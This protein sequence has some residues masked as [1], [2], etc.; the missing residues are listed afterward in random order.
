MIFIHLCNLNA[1]IHKIA[2]FAI[3]PRVLN[4]IPNLA[5]LVLM[6][7]NLGVF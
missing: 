6:F 1:N 7:V 3:I 4:F 5:P 2:G